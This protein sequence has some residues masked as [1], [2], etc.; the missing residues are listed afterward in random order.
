MQWREPP[1]A[2]NK[3]RNLMIGLM[4]IAA[5]WIVGGIV[6]MSAIVWLIMKLV[7]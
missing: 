6:A 3:S 7:G 4:W 5:M 1:H 2:H